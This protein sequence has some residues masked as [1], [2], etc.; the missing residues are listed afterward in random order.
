MSNIRM[1]AVEDLGDVAPMDPEWDIEAFAHFL[2]YDEHAGIVIE[3]GGEIVGA[4]MFR[5]I[6]GTIEIDRVTVA[7]SHRGRYLGRDMLDHLFGRLGGN[8]GQPW[9]LRA[10]IHNVD[11][12]DAGFLSGC[13][14]ML[15]A[16][17]GD[18]WQVW[19]RGIARE[20][21]WHPRNRISALLADS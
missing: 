19:V 12:S 9:R 21:K 7:E 8:V 16:G 6:R 20:S 5:T 3:Q 2:D 15:E 4:T 10:V 18:G 14:F 13:G 17:I 11:Y 1:F